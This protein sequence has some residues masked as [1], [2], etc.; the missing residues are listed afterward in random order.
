MVV[1]VVDQ[2]V[3]H[4]ASEE[5]CSILGMGIGLGDTGAT[6]QQASAG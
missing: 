4:H 6:Q 3:E 1:G 5:L 2:D